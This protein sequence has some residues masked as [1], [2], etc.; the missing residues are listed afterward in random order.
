MNPIDRRAAALAALAALALTACTASGNGSANAPAAANTPEGTSSLPSAATTPDKLNLADVC[1]ATV[2]LQLD[3]Q[4]EAAYGGWW[5][6]L[7]D[8]YTFDS[9]LKR[10]KGPLVAQ[11]H[12]TGVDLEVRIGGPG[13]GYQAVSAVMYSDPSV[14]V[15]QVATDEAIQFSAKQPTTAIFAPLD[16]SP[17]GIMWDPATYPNVHSIADLG[18]EGVKILYAEVAGGYP[19][20]YLTGIGVLKK[21]QLDGSY[22]GSPAPFVAAGGKAALQGFAGSEPYR[23]EH[24]VKAW[25][26]PSKFQTYYDTGYQP[27]IGALSIRSGDKQ[28]LAPCLKRLVPIMQQSQVDYVHSPDRAIGIMVEA[29]GKYNTGWTYSDGNARFELQKM[30]E[31]KLAGNG[32]NKAIGDFESSRVQKVIDVNTPVLTKEHKAPKPGL[33]VDDIVTNEFIDPSVGFAQ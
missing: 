26:K 30:A 4:P 24:D 7:G 21:S 32:P 29:A 1:P 11:G 18:K 9:K 23:Y 13:I 16:I 8:G 20:D 12:D 31:L 33:T 6:L 27:Y 25:G 17:L 19:I 14:T 3:W 5:T 2:V 10:A 22:D 15:G 28:K